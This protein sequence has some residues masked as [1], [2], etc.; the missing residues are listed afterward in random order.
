MGSTGAALTVG[1][2]ASGM[3]GGGWA[4]TMSAAAPVVRCSARGQ[5]VTGSSPEDSASVDAELLSRVAGG[6]RDALAGLYDRHRSALSVFLVRMTGDRSAA[7][8]ALQDTLLAVWRGAGG[9]QGRSSVRTWLY[10]IA[11]RQAYTRLRRRSPQLV[12]LDPDAVLVD[13]APTPEHVVVARADL[14]QLMQLIAVLAPA[15]REALLLF[16]VD[17][18]SYAEMAQVLEVP[19]G[20]V[21]SRLSNARRA[22][23]G[24]LAD[25]EGAE[26]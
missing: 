13:P 12:A 16:F 17:D 4:A 10:G 9:F 20:T 19:V 23:A 11:R 15:H 6:D 18:L 22:L 2:P 8:E 1:R 14:A 7:E 24:L 26:S 25:T 5:M 21:K 3:R